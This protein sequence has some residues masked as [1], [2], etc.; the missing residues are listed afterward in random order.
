[1]ETVHLLIQHLCSVR[2]EDDKA[3]KSCSFNKCGDVREIELEKQ[4]AKGI[5]KKA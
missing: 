3:S 2:A 4:T 5:N 1:M